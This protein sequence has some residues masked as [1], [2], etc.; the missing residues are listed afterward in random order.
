[1]ITRC[2]RP[3][4]GSSTTHRLGHANKEIAHRLNLSVKTVEVHK[5]NAM[6]KMCMKNRIDIVRYALLKGWLQDT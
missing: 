2:C 3:R 4:A 6:R 5:A 1:M